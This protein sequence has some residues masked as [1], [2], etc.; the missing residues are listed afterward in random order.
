MYVKYVRDVEGYLSKS[1]LV[2]FCG[3]WLHKLVRYKIVLFIFK[4]KLGLYFSS[5]K[6]MKYI[7]IL[8]ELR[9]T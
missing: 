1:L 5:L 7:Q 2:H 6:F 3:L 9:P 8:T 4:L